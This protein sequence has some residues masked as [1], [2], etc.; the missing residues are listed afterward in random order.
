MI[1]RSVLLRKEPIL[2]GGGL[3]FREPNRPGGDGLLNFG[4]EVRATDSVLEFGEDTC[5]RSVPGFH[6][7][8]RCP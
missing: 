3:R 5:G 1:L 6:F 7:Q 4:T 2:P 8:C